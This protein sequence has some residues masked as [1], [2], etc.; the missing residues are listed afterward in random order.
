MKWFL[1]TYTS[2]FNHRYRLFGHLFGGRYKSIIVDGNGNGY[3]R[4]VCDYVH[5]NPVRARLLTREQ[6]LR[7]YVWSS[8]GQYLQTSGKRPAWLRVDRLLGEMGIPQDSAAGRRQF[9]LGWKSG[10]NAMNR[11]SGKLWSGG[12][13]WAMKNSGRNCWRR[14]SQSSGGITAGRSGRRRS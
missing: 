3:L 13:I 8:Y 6:P 12:G 4:T 1:G 5:L 10:A 7:A 9:E 2:R 14:W 11:G